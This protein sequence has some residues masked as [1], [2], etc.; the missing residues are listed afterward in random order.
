VSARFQRRLL[1]SILSTFGSQLSTSISCPT[2]SL[3]SDQKGKP[4]AL[5]DKEKALPREAEGLFEGLNSSD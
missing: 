1:I 4:F 2:Y 5:Q 3:V